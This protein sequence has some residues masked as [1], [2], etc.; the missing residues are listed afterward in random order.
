M[1]TENTAGFIGGRGAWRLA[2]ALLSCKGFPV[3]EASDDP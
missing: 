2:Q 3:T 1:W